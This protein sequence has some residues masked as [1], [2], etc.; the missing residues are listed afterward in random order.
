MHYEFQVNASFWKPS[1]RIYD[2]KRLS[3]DSVKGK[4]SGAIPLFFTFSYLPLCEEW[5]FFFIGGFASPSVIGTLSAP[6]DSCRR[7]PRKH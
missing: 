3:Q 7:V 4:Y 1:P 2:F 5:Q 6:P